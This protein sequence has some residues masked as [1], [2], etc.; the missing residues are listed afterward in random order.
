[1][2]YDPSKDRVVAASDLR[3]LLDEAQAFYHLNLNGGLNAQPARLWG[4]E[5]KK[6]ETIPVIHNDRQIDQI[7][8]MVEEKT[9]TTAGI[10]MFNCLW[11]GHADNLAA[12]I[13]RN[14][15]TDA[16]GRRRRGKKRSVRL[17]FKVKYN[18]ADLTEIHVY[19]PELRDYVTLECKEE[20]LRG[21]SKKHF[22]VL[23]RWA[24]IQNLAFNT[25]EDRKIARATLNRVIRE[26]APHVAQK[27]RAKFAAL[28]DNGAGAEMSG[29]IVVAHVP[30]TYSG[31]APVTGHETAVATRS[32]G[33]AKPKGAPGRK[34]RKT[35]KPKPKAS[36]PPAPTTGSPANFG[37]KTSRR[38]AADQDW[39][40][41]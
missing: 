27:H 8:G 13:S 2:G 26:A 3:D 40:G 14:A 5:V 9:L 6:W 15:S 11:Y 30:S 23:Q 37:A 28:L 22:D 24:E 31:M 4:K 19:D 25:P 16:E 32:D 7:M 41:L 17:R 18:P 12:I 1:L 39:S 38:S 33:G 29:N 34:R 21:L 36:T 35:A 10:K 20:F